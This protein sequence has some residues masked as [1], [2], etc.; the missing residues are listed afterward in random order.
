MLLFLAHICSHLFDELGGDHS[1]RTDEEA[2]ASF[3][4]K[5]AWSCVCKVNL[6]L[7]HKCGGW[8]GLALTTEHYQ[9]GACRLGVKA[10]VHLFLFAVGVCKVCNESLPHICIQQQTASGMRCNTWSVKVLDTSKCSASL[11]R[12]NLCLVSGPD[13]SCPVISKW[14]TSSFATCQTTIV[15]G[16]IGRTM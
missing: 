15:L 3:L 9:T 5:L 14:L 8:L 13:F 4:C 10:A 12:G 1:V 16:N 11:E 2:M 7:E 6:P